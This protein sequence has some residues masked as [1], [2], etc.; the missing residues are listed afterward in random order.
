MFQY[1]PTLEYTLETSD[2]SEGVNT[3]GIA[4]KGTKQSTLHLQCVIENG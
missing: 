4:L 3:I 1:E 2:T